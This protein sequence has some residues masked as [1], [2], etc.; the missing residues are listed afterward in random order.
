M[1][2]AFFKLLLFVD[3]TNYPLAF[4]NQSIS[5]KRKAEDV[6]VNLNQLNYLIE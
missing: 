3:N 4:M 6:A 2:E 1:R 5:V